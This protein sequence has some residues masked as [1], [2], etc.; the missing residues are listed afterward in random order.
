M[1]DSPTADSSSLE[2]TAMKTI[3]VAEHNRLCSGIPEGLISRARRESGAEHVIVLL[4]GYFT[5]AGR[6]APASVA[7]RAAQAVREGADAVVRL[8]FA[9]T[10]NG[11]DSSAFGSISLL[12]R[13]HLVDE[14]VLPI[15]MSDPEFLNAISMMLFTERPDY[16]RAC[17]ALLSSGCPDGEAIVQAAEKCMPGAEAVLR[18][19]VTGRSVQLLTAV[20]KLYNPVKWHFLDLREA[21]D[22]AAVNAQPDDGAAV[23]P[24]ADGA[25]TG[26]SQADGA[27]AG[28]ARANAAQ[29]GSAISGNAPSEEG[30][31]EAMRSFLLEQDEP[32]LHKA[33]ADSVGLTSDLADHL[34][35]ERESIAAADSFSSMVRA[36][37]YPEDPEYMRRILLRMLAGLRRSGL[38][39][40]MLYTHA[41][42]AAVAGAG[43]SAEAYLRKL[44]E[45][46][47]TPVCRD[48]E[49]GQDPVLSSL[50]SPQEALSSD[51]SRL[52]LYRLDENARRLWE[53]T[54]HSRYTPQTH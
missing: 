31:A 23:N 51:E 53:A 4:N 24:Q 20:H 40:H 29:T 17:R 32:A 27:Q 15:R 41:P 8:P 49:A 13:L 6:P 28:N 48:P 45:S 2:G 11:D 10:L 52:L 26:N 25:R 33:L 21:D 50:K 18:D 47:W 39:M 5:D 34:L 16:S 7:S 46:A 1:T 43:P 42:Y 54:A 37:G 44:S 3:A 35:H 30:L 9:S 36:A 19:P 12:S 14:V 38:S 22:G